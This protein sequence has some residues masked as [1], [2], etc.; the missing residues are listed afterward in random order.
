MGELEITDFFSLGLSIEYLIIT[1]RE[2]QG[3]IYIKTAY[4]IELDPK[5]IESFRNAVQQDLVNLPKIDAEIEQGTLEGK[6][7]LTRSSKMIWITVVL[8]KRPTLFSREA[9]NWFSIEFENYYGEITQQLYTKYE[10]DISIFHKKFISKKSIDEIIEDILYLSLK[11]PH[12]IGSTKH[13]NITPEAKK[14]YNIAK[15]LPHKKKEG[16]SLIELYNHAKEKLGWEEGE[17]KNIIYNLLKNEILK[18]S[19]IEEFKAPLA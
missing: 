19:K 14:I 6:F 10:G 9:L 16:I 12:V 2:S 18:P 4:D 1:H 3:I 7:L 15:H 11:L 13:M 17:I 5:F 8:N